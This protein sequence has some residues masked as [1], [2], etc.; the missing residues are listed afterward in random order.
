MDTNL[1]NKGKMEVATF[2][3]FKGYR[4]NGASAILCEDGFWSGRVP[5]CN[6]KLIHTLVDL[7]TPNLYGF[8]NG[9]S[10]TMNNNI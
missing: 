5:Q 1:I 4:L 2:N 10:Y 7:H 6:R 9:H 8:A 3:C